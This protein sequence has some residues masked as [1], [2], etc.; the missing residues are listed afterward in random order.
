LSHGAVGAGFPASGSELQDVPVPEG[1]A[2]ADSSRR[3][4]R[5]PSLV[6]VARANFPASL[7]LELCV[8]PGCSIQHGRF[9]TGPDGQQGLKSRLRHPPPR[10]RAPEGGPGLQDARRRDIRTRAQPRW[11]T[12]YAWGSG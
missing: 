5:N 11:K 6:P 7:R 2:R 12:R 8:G 9:P 3:T 1:C 4:R 10:R